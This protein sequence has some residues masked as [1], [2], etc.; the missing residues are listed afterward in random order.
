M[1]LWTWIKSLFGKKITEQV[2]LPRNPRYSK[3]AWSYRCNGKL[4][5]AEMLY[6][7]LGAL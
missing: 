1:K 5:A 7:K 2:G 4:T 6:L 3:I